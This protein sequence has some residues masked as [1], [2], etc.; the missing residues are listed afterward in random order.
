MP[1]FNALLPKAVGLLLALTALTP[2]APAVA[3]D[4]PTKPVRIIVPFPP[5]AINDTVGRMVANHL[6][7]RLGKQF[8][9][10]NRGGAGGVVGAELVANAPKDGHTLL[11]VSLAIT[12]NPWLYTLPYDHAKAWAPVA[13]VATAPNVIGVHPD[14]PAQSVSDL[15]ALAKKQPGKLQYGSSGI[16]TFLHLGPELFKLMAGVD[17]LHIPYKGAAPAIIDVIG[18]R[19]SMAFG[20]I[21]SSIT[22]LRSGKLRALGV[23][24]LTRSATL[25]DVP[26]V[27]ESGLPGYEAANWIGVVAPAG[28]PPAII[29]KLHREIS[30]MQDSPEAQKQ[31]ANEGAEAMRMSSAD[32]GTFIASET[33]KWGRVVKEAGIKAQ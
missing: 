21:P 27:S 13:V 4:Y 9:V 28:T 1:R 18:G 19:T 12:V 20:S 24:A 2:T 6:S 3:Q 8:L 23:G 5:G 25:P 31:L 32:F 10:E 7:N 14:L 17:I 26:T 29:E 16:G 15:I 30:L 33:A 22:H 11:V